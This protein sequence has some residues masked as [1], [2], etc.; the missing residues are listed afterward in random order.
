[1]TVGPMS[2]ARDVA[3]ARAWTSLRDVHDRPTTF[4]VMVSESERDGL[5]PRAGLTA[6]AGLERLA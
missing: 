2:P 1:M 4:S 3:T 5:W 6:P